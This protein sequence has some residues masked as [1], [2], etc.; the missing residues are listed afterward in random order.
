[1][2]KVGIIVPR[3]MVNIARSAADE[4]GEKIT[5]LQ[6]FMDNGVEIAKQ[7]ELEGYDVIV[8]RGGIK[9]LLMESSINI[10]II[11]VP[12]TLMDVFRAIN[13][14]EK[15]SNNV[16]LIVSN[17]I[18][19]IVNNYALIA[20]K[21]INI[22]QVRNGT[23][24][25]G[26]MENLA[27]E[28]E[29]V[30][31]GIGT[32]TKYA[33]VHDIT[34]IV[35][36]SGKESFI[37]SIE[38]AIKIA[39]ATRKERVDNERIKA[40]INYS[41]EGVICIDKDSNINIFNDSAQKLLKCHASEMLGKKINSVLPELELKE[42]LFNGVKESGEIIEIK[43]NR[44]MV[45]KIP[46]TN[47]G[48]VVNVVAIL[49]DIEEIQ[50]MEEKIRKDIDATGHYATYT[51]KDVIGTSKATKE[52]MRIG[53]E[54]AKVDSTVLIQGETGTG[55]EIMAQSIHNY[56]NRRNGPFVAVNCAALPENLL[57]SELF[58]YDSGAFTGANRKGKKGLFEMA[59]GGSIFL[60][61]ISEMNPLLQG[62]LLRVLQEKKIMK[63]GGNKLIPIDIR[64]I[65]ATNK[66]LRSLVKTGDFREDLFYRL[67]VL[68][69]VL[70]PLRN[71]RE[72]I[73]S[74]LEHFIGIYCRRLGKETLILDLEVKRHLAE[75]NWYGNVRELKNFCERLVVMAKNRQITL[76]DITSEIL[77]IEGSNKIERTREDIKKDNNYYENSLNLDDM[78]KI[79]INLALESTNGNIINAAKKLGISRTTLWRR[80]KEYEIK[81]AK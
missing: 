13:E 3:D 52:T 39:L 15:L 2:I 67:N 53:Q 80:M 6:G 58:G 68:K 32:I 75:H 17:N 60:D 12:I 59:H 42:I 22:F 23:D 27:S 19:E 35:I 25:R 40:I 20:D 76:E 7:L 8:A 5:V 57:E 79:N 65:T 46:I 4:F 21:K 48:E 56:S 54:Y 38:Q 14:A 61:E 11:S 69:I 62:R 10:P 45:S 73:I 78:E 55:K 33:F 24:I 1:M 72:D 29:K 34:P 44:F 70:T 16:P 9:T 26:K 50:K 64:I 30:V 51:F 43:Q 31:V 41:Y 18:V 63:V 37:S 49:R 74:F 47:R 66:D 71:R 77:Y 81:V 36:K 28:G